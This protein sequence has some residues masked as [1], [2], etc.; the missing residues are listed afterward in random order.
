MNLI[1]TSNQKTTHKIFPKFPHLCTRLGRSKN[2]IAKPTFKQYFKRTQRK[3]R[4]VPLHP[5][6]K[7]E[8]E[9]KNL[10]EDKRIVKLGKC[11]DE[12]FVS[13]VVIRV[14][15]DNSIKLALDSK[16]LNDALH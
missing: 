15:S 7:L 12:Y 11:S 3:P 4:K 10:I 1:T 9:L 14:K 6:D 16:E 5:I 2:H 8:I 13:P